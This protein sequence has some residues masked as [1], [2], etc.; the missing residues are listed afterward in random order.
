M[1][2]SCLSSN[3]EE[4]I[5]IKAMLCFLRLETF[6]CLNSWRQIKKPGRIANYSLHCLS[7]HFKNLPCH[8]YL[9]W[10]WLKLLFMLGCYHLSKSSRLLEEKPEHLKLRSCVSCFCLCWQCVHFL[11]GTHK[12]Y[13]PLTRTG[14]FWF[15]TVLTGLSVAGTPS[16]LSP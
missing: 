12:G 1:F 7:H 4:F 10:R 15:S 13:K 2:I 16:Q 6:I 3:P 5:L 14:G 8:S 9:S 11:V